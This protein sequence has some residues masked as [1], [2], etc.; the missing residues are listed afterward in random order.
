VTLLY[1]LF[2]LSSTPNKTISPPIARK[3]LPYS[4]A[5]IS[6]HREKAICQRW[7]NWHLKFIISIDFGQMVYFRWQPVQIFIHL[8]QLA[9]ELLPFVDKFKMDVAAILYF[10]FV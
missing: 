1:P 7:D 2:L 4:L 10:I 6:S 3:S 9:V 5:L 8:C